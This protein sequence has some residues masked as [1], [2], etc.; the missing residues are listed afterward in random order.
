MTMMTTAMPT[1]SRRAIPVIPDSAPFSGAQ[2][3]WLN[4]FL[5]GLVNEP[6]AQPVSES[7]APALVEQEEELPWHDPALSMDERLKLAEGQPKEHVLM[8]AMAQLDCGACGYVCKTYSQAI[9]RG[10]E[11]DLTKCAPGGT[12]TAKK[13]KQLLPAGGAASAGVVAVSEVRL[14]VPTT[15]DGKHVYDR[16][17]PFPARMLACSPLT[18]SGSNK[19]T[20]L[21]ALDLKNSGLSYKVGDS[22]GVYPQ[23]CPDAVQWILEA[24]KAS[25]AEDVPDRDGSRTDLHELLLRRCVITKPSVRLVELLAESASNATEATRLKAMV[26]ESVPEG[27]EIVDLLTQFPSARP[28]IEEFVVA[29]APLQ[30]RLYSI[31]SSLRAH[32]DQVHLT[33]GVVRYLNGRGRQCK[34]VASSFLAERVRP[35]EKVKVFLQPSHRFHIPPDGQTPMIMVGP[36]TGIAPFRA[37]LQERKG[38][39]AT[40]KN[41]LF[42]GDQCS[43]CDFLYE[44][45]LKGYQREGLLTRL[46]TAFSRDQREKVYV[47][48]RM[49]Q[50]GPAIWAWLQEGACFYVCG[51][52]QRMARDVDQTLKQIVAEQGKLSSEAPGAYVAELAKAKR[53]QRDVY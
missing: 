5:A 7:T 11:P 41:W 36:G 28:E 17:N 13:L 35:G 8:A 43:E 40:G 46:D 15:A 39:G 34:G 3:A 30:P 45:E 29:L 1:A 27:V 50:N 44:D 48:H 22:L 19:D 49:L 24:F 14:K 6:S 52:A 9:A 37:F 23:N 21:V 16:R 51:D 25:G 42:F 18:K 12:E 10:E 38:T 53:Y 47:Q 32:P 2:R 33:V 20:R 31:A 26:D 4:G